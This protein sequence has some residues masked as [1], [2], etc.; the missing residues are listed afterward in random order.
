MG[1]EPNPK[2]KLDPNTVPLPMA[3][4]NPVRFAIRGVTERIPELRT[5]I[6][7]QDFD[8]DLKRYIQS[9]L[10]ELNSNAAEIHL[11]DVEFGDGEGFDLHISV[12]A[13]TLGAKEGVVFKRG[14]ASDSVKR[15]D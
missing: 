5:L 11:H 4:K 10:D 9:E 14:A 12:R 2:I 8:A 6:E 13:R 3:G 1:Q 7:A 15:V